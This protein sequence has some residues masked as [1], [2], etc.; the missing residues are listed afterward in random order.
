MVDMA[1][2]KANGNI[3]FAEF[4]QRFGDGVGE[5]ILMR[6]SEA[7]WSGGPVPAGMT[8][9][10]YTHNACNHTFSGTIVYEGEEFGFVIESGDRNGTQ[11]DEWGPAEDVGTYQPPQP[12]V[13]RLVPVDPDLKS[14]SMG[15]WNVYM[16]WRNE[17]WF[18]K[19]ESGYNYDRHFAPGGK[20]KT[21]WQ[22]NAA[23]RGLR[24]VSSEEADDIIKAPARTILSDA[25]IYM[26]LAEAAKSDPA[27]I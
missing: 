12:T 16:A 10:V 4:C 23:R 22:G 1:G 19:I 5:D 13:Y 15:M 6:I 26:A 21:Y 9:D 3:A 25:Q 8:L 20:T 24:F 14:K 7:A 2:I 27:A 18:K 11:I 17:D